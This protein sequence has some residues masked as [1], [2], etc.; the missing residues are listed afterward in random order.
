MGG[1]DHSL[2]TVTAMDDTQGPLNGIDAHQPPHGMAEE[3]PLRRKH[4]A[5][6][7]NEESRR[8]RLRT[9]YLVGSGLDVPGVAR[10]ITL[11]ARA[12]GLS[13]HLSGLPGSDLA[14]AGKAYSLEQTLH[15]GAQ[16]AGILAGL[17]DRGVVHGQVRPEHVLH[18]P[19]TGAVALL[20]FGQAR[21]E[22]AIANDPEGQLKQHSDDLVD[23]GRLLLWMGRPELD[24]EAIGTDTQTIDL[25]EGARLVLRRL[26]QAGQPGGYCRA[27]AAR[28]DLERLAQ[29]PDALPGTALGVPPDLPL[30][31]AHLGRERE[32]AQLVGAYDEMLAASAGRD[33]E[34][35][36]VAGAKAVFV[37]GLAGI[38]KTAVIGDACQLLIRRGARVALGKFNQFGDSRPLWALTQALDRLM[39]DIGA[40]SEVRRT[41]QAER[42]RDA[43]R[44]LAQVIIDAVPGLGALLGPQPAPP[45]LSGWANRM[46]FEVL[47]RRF[48]AALTSPEEPLVLVLDDMHWADPESLAM[49]RSL[50][51]DPALANLL[52]LASYRTEAVTPGHPLLTTLDAIQADTGELRRVTVKAWTPA[53]IGRL[54]EHVTL[55]DKDTLAAF[56]ELLFEASHGNPLGVLHAL[57]ATYDSGAIAYKADAASWVIDLERARNALDNTR[58][59]DL[60]QRQL[61]TLPPLG[62][63]A[64]ST[65]A[66]LGA[67]FSLD[68]LATAMGLANPLAMAALWPAMARGLLGVEPENGENIALPRF[69]LAHDIVQQAAHGL[70]AASAGAERHASIARALFSAYNMGEGMKDH[71]YDVILHFNRAGVAAIGADERKNVIA[72]NMSA[73][74]TAQS[75]RPSSISTTPMPCLPRRIGRT[76]PKL[77]ST[78]PGNWPKRPIWPPTSSASIA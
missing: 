26:L 27:D 68:M 32:I 55:R 22:R 47:M 71:L 16:L 37:D 75:A 54:L 28:A 59:L 51:R 31:V 14:S 34:T 65:G 35:A 25:P 60:V 44:D 30:P 45:A 20:D 9:H 7:R 39:A 58:T 49:V 74:R 78:S 36:T 40:D 24:F 42:I 11:D 61:A 41:A 5:W 66:Y 72:L 29:H 73:G 77:P 19:A 23:L 12:D 33:A 50:L 13:L 17:A 3:A 6:G 57:R 70:V 63:H 56:S 43:L 38:G 10:P 69:R 18:D 62:Q 52:I 53:E 1:Q 4:A 76:P 21:F 48:V 15:I 67:S 46:R 8:W 64:L 2:T